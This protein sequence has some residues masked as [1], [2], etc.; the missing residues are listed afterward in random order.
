MESVLISILICIILIIILA[1]VLRSKV[2][3][4]WLKGIGKTDSQKKVIK[5]LIYGPKRSKIKIQEFDEL[6]QMMYSDRKIYEKAKAKFNINETDIVCHP[7]E[8]IA[9]EYLCITNFDDNPESLVC[10]LEKGG[11][12]SAACSSF[13][14]IFGRENLYIYRLDYRFDKTKESETANTYPYEKLLCFKAISQDLHNVRISIDRVSS[15][16]LAI[17]DNYRNFVVSEDEFERWEAVGKHFDSPELKEEIRQKKNESEKKVLRYFKAH[18]NLPLTITDAEYDSMIV[19]ALPSKVL[20]SMGMEQ[21]AIE[22]CDVKVAEPISFR[23]FVYDN[24]AKYVQGKDKLWR[25]SVPQHTWLFF[26]KHQVYV[27]ITSLN[28]D[29][30]ILQEATQEIFYN[31]IASIRSE[32][33]SKV[34]QYAD[35]VYTLSYYKFTLL[36]AGDSF[37]LTLPYIQ[38][39]N[40]EKIKGMRNLLRETKNRLISKSDDSDML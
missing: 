35:I 7:C 14:A 27:Y 8:T 29:S 6:C 22:A 2:L 1:I 40:E 30:S 24:S 36:F 13:M 32:H 17:T 10:N 26:G 39:D 9:S 21:M 3:K 11:F 19:S 16:G 38:G 37:S 28:M 12:R 18:D 33:I 23:S 31:D 34:E 15:N 20:M 25:S 4:V 5:F